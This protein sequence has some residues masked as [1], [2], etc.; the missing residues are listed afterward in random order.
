MTGTNTPPL[1]F[2]GEDPA[3]HPAADFISAA[4]NR[5]AR[6]ARDRRSDFHVISLATLDADGAPRLRSV[7]LRSFEPHDLRLTFHTDS[8]SAKFAEL[9]R[10]RRA[11]IL[12]YDAGAKLQIRV[13]GQ[14]ELHRGDADSA[15]VWRNLPDGARQIYRGA[16]APGVQAEPRTLDETI[17]E[18]DAERH[19]AVCRLTAS[20]VD[21]LYLRAAGHRRAIGLIDDAGGLA[22][23]W[24]AA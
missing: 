24:V 15:S 17:G 8:R 14:V 18:K 9:S 3:H 6:G 21:V 19:F 20:M 23:H 16:R 13:E 2:P 1:P 10:D 22:A 5:L 11:A 12:A 7:V 4:L